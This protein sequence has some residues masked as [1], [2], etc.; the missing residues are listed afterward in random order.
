MVSCLKVIDGLRRRT[1]VPQPPAPRRKDS[2]AGRIWAWEWLTRRQLHGD[3]DQLLQELNKEDRKGHKNSPRIYPEL[4][5]EMVK[6]L[7]PLLKKKDTNM[8]RAQEVGLKLAVTLRHLASGNDYTSLQYSFR[9][10]QSSICRFIP[11]VCQAIIDIYKPEVVKCPKTPEEWNDG[12]KRF[13]SKWNYFNCVGALDGK[14]IA[15][16]KP[17]EGGPG[18]GGTCQKCN[19]ARAIANNRAGLPQGKNL[20]NDD[21]PIPLRI[22][23]DDAFALNTWLMKPYSHQSQDPTE[24]TY[25]YRLSRARHVVENAFGLL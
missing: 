7:T 6:R 14:H 8:R 17:K 13:A 9:V 2:R 10:S 20:P 15:I 11:V 21:E 25:S 22:V 18:D 19:L 23:A 3:Y 5:E 12:A 24:R 16:K 1:R 4:F